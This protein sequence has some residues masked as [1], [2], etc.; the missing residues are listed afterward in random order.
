[1][2]KE[3]YL[4]ERNDNRILE[5]AETVS[6]MIAAYNFGH[7]HE[8]LPK[9]P[10]VIASQ[11]IDGNSIM[12]VNET[13]DGRL[14]VICHGAMYPNFDRGEDKILGMQIVEMGSVIV[15]PA[16]RGQGIGSVGTKMLFD[17]AF[18]NWD[19]VLCLAKVKQVVT[20]RV[21][22]KAAISP[23]SFWEFPYLS[24]LTCTCEGSSERCGFDSCC[25]RRTPEESSQSHFEKIL[26]RD[27]PIGYMPC[28]LV[29]S[30]KDLAYRFEEVC[31]NMHN[32]LLNTS[33]ARGV[34]SGD[35]MRTADEFFTV[36]KSLRNNLA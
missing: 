30:D 8:M 7:P 5:A 18:K 27:N 23:V 17:L 22:D 31:G 10:D 4:L 6:S 35:S 32:N 14:S 25:Y 2:T 36:L 26:N 33:L 20:A 9:S 21:F 24:Y 16:Y 28:T 19:K 13:E 1:M 3:I 12:L 15:H 11:F 34:I 29:V